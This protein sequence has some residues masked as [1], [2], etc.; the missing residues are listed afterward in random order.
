[1]TEFNSK[2]KQNSRILKIFLFS[3][4]ALFA[5]A[6]NAHAQSL[7]QGTVT[8]ETGES[9]PGVSVVV[10]G[11]T[12]G[13]VTDVNGK[14]SIQATSKDILSF[15]Y[16]GMAELDI[17]VAGQKTINVVMKDDVA[18]LDEVIVVGYGTAK[19]QSLTGAVSA[20]KGDELLKAPATNVSSLL[21]GRLPGISS[22]QVS[23]EPGDD[24]AVLRVRGS[25]YNVTYIVDGMP[26]SIN[27]IDPNDIESVSVLKDGAS[28]AVYGLKGAGG[29]IIVT[30]KRGQEGKSRITYNG[31]IGASM[32]ANF[33]QFM[34]GLQFAYYYNMADMM[35]KLANG[36]IADMKQYTPVFTKANVEAMLNGDP[37][38]GWDN[39]NYIDKV[40]GTGINQ[41]HNIT[42]QGGSDKMRYFTSVGYLGQDGNIDNFTYK[43]YNLRTNIETQLAKNFQLSL[44]VAGNVGKR[45]TPGYASGGTDSNSELGEQGWLSVAHQTVMMHPYLPEKYDG[46]YTATTQNNTSLPNSPLA[47][48]YESGYKHTNSFDLQTNLSLQYNLPWVKG[49][50]VKVTGAYD[51]KTSHNKNLNTPYST[52]INKM[53]TSTTDWTWTKADDPRGTANGINLG[54]GQFSSRQMV[55][56]GSINYANS[57]GKHNVEAMVLAEIRDYKENSFSG[58]NKN[59]SFAELPELSFG[60]PADSPISGYSDAN[61]SIGYVFRLKYDYDNKY[62]AEFTGRYD[63]SY[64]F[65]G[66]VSGKRWAFFPSAS[67]AWRISKENFMS[68]LT[69]LDDMKIRASVGLLGNDDVS[70]YAFLSTYNLMDGNK[71]AYQTILNGKV[72]Q[73]LRASVIANP[74]LTWENT[75]TYNAGF[76]FTMW[77]GLLG[78]EFDAFYNYTYDILTA[79][80]GDYP[81]SMGGYYYTYANYNKVDSKGVEITVSHRNKL[82]LAGK[83]F[84]YGASFNL[85]FARNRYLRYPDSPNTVEWRKRTGRSVDASVVWVAEGLFRSEEEIDNSAWYG[86]RP[87]VGDIKYKDLNGDGKIDE[88]DRTRV[89]RGNRP[90]LT[91]GLNLNCAWNGFDL[92]A[93]FTGGALFDVSLTGTY[94]NGYDDNTVWTQAFKEGANSP[95]YLVQNAYTTENPNGTFPRL[96]LGNQGHGGDNGLASTFWLRNG[97]YLR[98]KSAQL[99]YTFPKKWMS[100]VGIQNLR[101]YVEGSNLFTISGLPDGIDPES[102]G[103]NNGYYPQQRTI[104]GG[105]TLTF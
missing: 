1:M 15:T 69:F 99:G 90:E 71:N 36:S 59:M 10:K 80:G 61:R 48:I 91:Y 51:Y 30:T 57:F 50:S 39:V 29:V 95:L 37:T 74:T 81:P 96:T 27:D 53:P 77:N 28:A 64:K 83:P 8:D 41:K 14:Y 25:I 73:A 43:R 60:Q 85:T 58:Y 104:M 11:T 4:C 101:I 33:P 56:Q 19:K 65:A 66:N 97:R 3:I 105:I 70:P 100:P 94:Y 76:D 13:T 23:G 88:D 63:G 75:L 86:T 78:M 68:D 49:L 93:Q 20:V 98:L 82:N 79:M 87:N 46:L 67:V 12:N 21:G 31:S 40:F 2:I 38:D 26:R 92:S 22:V 62:L 47:A 102:P 52:Y 18:S 89:G 35:D 54:E 34:N 24:Q 32:N 84:S 44:G 42:V 103:V 5:C 45:E 9:L 16:V 72:M 7:V 6:I 55:G 17:K